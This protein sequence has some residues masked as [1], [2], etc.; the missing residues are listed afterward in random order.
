M[1]YIFFFTL[2]TKMSTKMVIQQPKPFVVATSSNQWSSGIC[3]C[4]KDCPEC[5]FAFWCFPCFACK[6]AN[7]YGECLCLPM[8]DSFGIIPPITLAMRVS[9]RQRYGITGTICDDCVYSFFCGP[10]SWCQ[11]SREMKTRLQPITL[12]NTR[13]K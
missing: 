4:G 7:D 6:T 2:S 5:C 8:L 9:M 10:C 1:S 13:A 3:D 12:I 11:M